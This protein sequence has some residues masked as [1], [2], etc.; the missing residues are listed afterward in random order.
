MRQHFFKLKK[1]GV[2]N[3]MTTIRLDRTHEICQK[4]DDSKTYPCYVNG[5]FKELTPSQVRFYV[6]KSLTIE[7]RLRRIEY[8]LGIRSEI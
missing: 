8:R 3:S 2:G 1:N 6:E 5:K 7:E 4:H